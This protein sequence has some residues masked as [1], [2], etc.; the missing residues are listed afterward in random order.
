MTQSN[1]DSHKQ[2]YRTWTVQA[3]V[4]YDHCISAIDESSEN[5]VSTG[6]SPKD[7]TISIMN[8][9]CTILH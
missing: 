2:L 3:S 5:P 8:Q 9:K 7:V 4:D 6:I 1:L